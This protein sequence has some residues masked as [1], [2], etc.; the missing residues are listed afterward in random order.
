M[1]RIYV[2]S[3]YAGDYDAVLRNIAVA[4]GLC[5]ALVTEG[6]APFAPHLL[7]TR[8]L[9]DNNPDQRRAGI[10]CGHAFLAVCDEVWVWVHEGE[11]SEG[12]RADIE[13]AGFLGIPV[14]AWAPSIG[15]I[16]WADYLADKTS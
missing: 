10:T 14:L 5:R 3:K 1:K 8:F 2:C 6:H 4:E 16:P 12:M 11:P 13:A 9:D 7:Y 15:R